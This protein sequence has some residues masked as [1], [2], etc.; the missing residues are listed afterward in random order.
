M[1]RTSKGGLNGMSAALRHDIALRTV[2]G[3]V[4]VYLELTNRPEKS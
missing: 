2:K 4:S 1:I 3:H